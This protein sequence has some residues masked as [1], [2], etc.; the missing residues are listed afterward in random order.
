[1]DDKLNRCVEDAC[2]NAW[3]ALK[4]IFYDG[5]LIRLAEG[6]TRRTNSVNV[7]HAGRE[8]LDEK[9]VHCERLYQGH[10][11]PAIF[12]IRTTD[13]PALERALAARGY[14]A[15]DETCTLYKDFGDGIAM[16][17]GEVEILEGGAS[18]EWLGAQARFARRPL[19]LD[20]IRA[21]LLRQVALPVAFAARRD[22]QGQIVS[23]AY[24][25]LHARLVSLQW[26]VTDPETRGKGHAR[27]NLSALMRW[28]AQ[29]G[30]RGACLQV[31]A[32]NQPAI[33]LYQSLGFSAELYRYHYRV[34]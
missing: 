18:A 5:W 27:A 32:A 31:F 21:R 3:P 24:G 8:M 16:P 28:A 4:E 17:A 33:G 26:V 1:M 12:R 10:G 15:E 6:H 29:N 7:L 34:R 11:L 25:A 13:D 2:L 14:G 23:V 30:A 9:I 20:D 19:Q 22:A